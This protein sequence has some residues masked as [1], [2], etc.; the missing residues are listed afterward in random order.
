MD[1]L[2]SV[3]GLTIA[4]SRISIIRRPESSTEISEVEFHPFL[5]ANH[6]AISEL[7]RAIRKTVLH[8][9]RLKGYADITSMALFGSAWEARNAQ[10]AL[11]HQ[12]PNLVDKAYDPITQF[13]LLTGQKYYGEMDYSKLRRLQLDF[14]S[15]GSSLHVELNS[16]Q[17]NIARI[18]TRDF[19]GFVR[20]LELIV[21]AWDPDIL[22][23]FGLEQGLGRLF[24]ES[25]NRGIQLNLGRDNGIASY[26]ERNT[27]I[28]YFHPRRHM[29]SMDVRGREVIDLGL[30]LY[31]MNKNMH[32]LRSPTLDEGA[33]F[34]GI[35]QGLPKVRQME[36]LSTYLM[37]GFF[38][39]TQ[40]APLRMQKAYRLGT[41]NIIDHR[42]LSEYLKRR[43]SI[44][45]PAEGLGFTGGLV[46]LL[47]PGKTAKGSKVYQLD[48]RAMYPSIIRLLKASPRSD[49]LGAF[50][51]ALEEMLSLKNDCTRMRD[52]ESS[53]SVEYKVKSWTLAL[54]K[55]LCNTF[56][57]YLGSPF[58][59]FNDVRQAARV[60][61]YGRKL[62][63]KVRDALAQ[64]QEEGLVQVHAINTDGIHFSFSGDKDRLRSVVDT[65]RSVLPT[66]FE[67]ALAGPWDS[68]VFIANNLYAL[69]D[70]SDGDRLTLKGAALKGRQLEKIFADFLRDEVMMWLKNDNDAMRQLYRHTHDKILGRYLQ[71]EDLEISRICRLSAA[72]YQDR[73]R[74]GSTS[75]QPHMEIILRSGERY[76]Q[77]DVISYYVA[78]DSSSK[79]IHAMAAPIENFSS[80]DANVK[81]Y[82]HRLE[83]IVSNIFRSM[84]EDEFRQVFCLDYWQPRLY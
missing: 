26:R 37:P 65:V 60:A 19:K 43:H 77:G 7:D 73:V 9:E 48:V 25:N 21:A 15:E 6:K 53:D 36:V 61:Q 72:S 56:F 33:S 79:P 81:Y 76:R 54:V 63:V 27:D 75:R 2:D 59:H 45:F 50:I 34:F 70:S 44:P 35:D 20:E 13:Q 74:Q 41:A 58:Y 32:W 55:R 57:G 46:E 4:G 17:G 23:V 78:G 42:L 69:L 52:L 39:I 62:I 8:V 51:P 30:A 11:Q 83:G 12:N 84:P 10:I 1:T 16:S 18:E 28:D 38:L 3:V 67:M 5:L 47:N 71:A 82:L 40:H 22:E 66:G 14:A 80:E 31:S 24:V 49:V 29:P 68:G 64:Y